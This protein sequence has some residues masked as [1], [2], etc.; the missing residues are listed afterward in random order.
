MATRNVT[1]LLERFAAAERDFLH[2]EFLAPAVRG[3]E[4]RVRMAGEIPDAQSFLT[5]PSQEEI[6]EITGNKTRLKKLRKRLSHISW[7][8]GR[9]KETTARRCNQDEQVDGRFWAGRFRCTRLDDEAAVLACSVYVDL[10]PVRAKI[11]SKPEDAQYTAFWHRIR[12]RQ[13]RLKMKRSRGK[14]R[15]ARRSTSTLDPDA[16]PVYSHYH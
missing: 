11:V 6:D 9:L 4:V 15:A 8:M 14:G 16:D 10:N 2:Q 13:S 3:G 12:A 5:E 1:R 7:F